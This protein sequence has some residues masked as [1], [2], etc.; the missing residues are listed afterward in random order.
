MKFSRRG[1][2]LAGIAALTGSI[3]IPVST[4]GTSASAAT[5]PHIRPHVRVHPDTNY[6]VTA[7]T[8]EFQYNTTGFCPAGSGNNPC[9]GNGSAGDYGTI[10]RTPSGYSNGGYGNYAPFTTAYKGTWDA[11]IDGT[12]DQ[13]QGLGCPSTAVEACTGP[14]ALFGTGAAQGAENVF[15]KNGFT[16]TDDLYLSPSTAGP[17]GSLVDNDVAMNTSAGTFGIDNVIT[18]CDESGGFTLNFSHNSPGP[19]TGD[20]VVTT[21]GWYRFVWVFSN[22][23]GYAYLTESVYTD[24]GLSL[25][26]TSGPEPLGGGTAEPIGDWG[27]PLYLW[28]PTEQ[29]DGLPLA[30]VDLELGQ[31][32]KGYT[33][34]S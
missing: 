18:A 15:P 26:A 17:A 12:G 23:S 21:D 32:K 3:A 10:D 31:H 13:N 6:P 9:D 34:S 1:A 25:V 11:L 20:P 14:Y 33:P 27:G 30:N 19:C 8:Q 24:P 4:L 2:Y 16:V 22:V 7:W 28:F 29:F 5:H